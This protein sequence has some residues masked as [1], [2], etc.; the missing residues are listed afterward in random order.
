MA[1]SHIPIYIS[2]LNKQAQW[3]QTPL[4][5]QVVL[6]LQRSSLTELLPALLERPLRLVMKAVNC[7]YS[8][9]SCILIKDFVF[10]CR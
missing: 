1:Q 10:L 3:F 4:R 2:N 5:P 8:N 7:K 6:M 9:N